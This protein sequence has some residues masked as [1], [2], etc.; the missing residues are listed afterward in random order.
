[1]RHTKTVTEMQTRIVADG[2]TCDICGRDSPCIDGWEEEPYEKLDTEVSFRKGDC[3]PDDGFTGDTY[4]IDVC[5]ECF[6]DKLIP[7]V[8]SFGKT[9]IVPK[10]GW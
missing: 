8:E 10:G 2:I 3:F 5:P 6:V 1:M 7:W 9:K 4:S